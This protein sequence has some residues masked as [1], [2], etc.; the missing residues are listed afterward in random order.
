MNIS[1]VNTFRTAN[2]LAPVVVD[3]VAKAAQAKRQASNKA[4]RA[5]ESRDMK[6]RRGS[7]SK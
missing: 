6:S 3:T 2:G 4:A 5:A 1:Q 7:R